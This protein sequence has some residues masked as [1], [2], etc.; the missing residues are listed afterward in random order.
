MDTLRLGTGSG[1]V[2]VAHPDDETIWMGGTMLANPQVRWTIVSLCRA[3]DPDRAP[4]FKRV[5]KHYGARGYILDAEDEGRMTIRASVPVFDHALAL[6]RGKKFAYV[7]SHGYTG[8]YGHPRHKGVHR[9]VRSLVQHS[10]VQAKQIFWFS[11]ELRDHARYAT[12]RRDSPVGVRLPSDIQREKR[13]IIEE[14][15]GF[16]PQSFESRSCAALETFVPFRP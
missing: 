11:Y 1:L 10:H 8:E 16:S 14:L 4:K 7:F 9:A 5:A 13:R 6:L 3:S 12:P 15:Y 2:V